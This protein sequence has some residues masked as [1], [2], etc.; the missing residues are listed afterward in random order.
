MDARLPQPPEE[1]YIDDPYRSRSTL[2]PGT[3]R[4]QAS[5]TSHASFGVDYADDR[6]SLPEREVRSWNRDQ[7]PQRDQYSPVLTRGAPD[8]VPMFEGNAQSFS[9]VD[10]EPSASRSSKHRVRPG[11]H[12][13]Q[14][15]PDDIPVRLEGSGEHWP[16][17]GSRGMER[18]RDELAPRSN[19]H[20]R[21]PMPSRR[22]GS[23]LDRLSLVD[24]VAGSSSMSSPSLRDRVQIVP[25]K[26]DRE[27]MVGNDAARD[28]DMDEGGPEDSASKKPRRRMKMKRARRSGGQ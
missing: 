7:E 15:Y 9:T 3:L 12:S 10:H 28:I 6:E 19:N 23:L 4:R 22:G 27:E 8:R 1:R 13:V 26:R 14:N 2:S 17:D 20:H 25:S 16:S 11:S 24:N 21:R 18:T 5:F